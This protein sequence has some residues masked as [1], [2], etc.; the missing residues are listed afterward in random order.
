MASLNHPEAG[1]L[2]QSNGHKARQMATGTGN[3]ARDLFSQELRDNN[4]GARDIDFITKSTII[5]ITESAPGF[6]GSNKYLEAIDAR[7]EKQGDYSWLRFRAAEMNRAAIIVVLNPRTRQ[8]WY[9]WL[10]YAKKAVDDSWQSMS[11]D[12]FMKKLAS[13]ENSGTV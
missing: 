13:L 11:L 12:L 8:V 9:R 4:I 3:E 7:R 1:S 6:E 2:R 10:Y 5:E